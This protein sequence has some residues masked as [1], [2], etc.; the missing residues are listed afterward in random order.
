M[1]DSIFWKYSD[2]IKNETLARIEIN[3]FVDLKCNFKE[4]EVN[5]SF[6]I[7]NHNG[8]HKEEVIRIM[9]ACIIEPVYANVIFNFNHIFSNSVFYFALKP[10]VPQYLKTFFLKD[11][12][13]I[14][15]A[16]IFDGS[17]GTNYFHF[18]TDIFSKLW[19]LEKYNINR[20][21]PL[22]ID[23]RT[24][25]TRFFQYL[26]KNTEVSSYNWHVMKKYVKS[27][28]TYVLRPLAYSF[29]YFNKTKNFLIGN[30][31]KK[32]FPERI[33]LNRS[34]SS[35]RFIENFTDVEKVLKKY[36]F[37][38]FDTN[39]IPLNEQISLFMGAKIIISI[40]GA[41]NTNIIFSEPGT[42]FLEISP[43]NRIASQ[44]YGLSN[45]LNI[46][47]DVILGGSLPYI[48]VYPEKGFTLDPA[49]LESYILNLLSDQN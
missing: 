17:V 35:G 2:K 10:S 23:E 13:E 25:S 48:R 24:F 26:L 43:K 34:V 4:A 33:F 29:E 11:Y 5:E 41:G 22:L 15:E 42:K 46:K 7:S 40:H 14:D 44:Y 32:Q 21:L 36:D 31:Q 30:L 27:K 38:I 28:T 37:Q 19:M 1:I 39:D 47:Y 18:F 12:T 8:I 9:Q 3:P 16:I 6:T 49:R 45:V 20:S